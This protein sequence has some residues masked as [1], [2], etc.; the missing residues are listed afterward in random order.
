M[1]S[2]SVMASLPNKMTLVSSKDATLA[3][4][5]NLMNLQTING[6]NKV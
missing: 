5:H 1:T 3:S 6:L 2:T 4:V